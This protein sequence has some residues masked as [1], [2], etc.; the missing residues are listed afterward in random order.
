M[1]PHPRFR[2]IVKWGGAAL[3]AAFLAAWLASARWCL[4]WHDGTL[5][6]VVVQC[7][8]ARITC[9]TGPSVSY[10]VK[11][12]W[13]FWKLPETSLSVWRPRLQL[14]SYHSTTPGVDV[15][16]TYATLPLWMPVA[17]ALVPTVAAW[18]LDG[19]ARR[20][21]APHLCPKCRYDRT[22]LAAEAACPECGQLP[23]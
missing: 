16:I 20:R 5:N 17:L 2:R 8:A 3:S 23:A 13:Y 4:E 6:E 12:G 11:N 18:Y 21:V 1:R 19:R 9:E 15:R 10:S 14:S 22:G 7:G